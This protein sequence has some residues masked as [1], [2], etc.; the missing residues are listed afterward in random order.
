MEMLALEHPPAPTNLNGSTTGAG[1][2]GY[3]YRRTKEKAI[4]IA[5]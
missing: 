3:V 5:D 4:K 1:G 2:Y